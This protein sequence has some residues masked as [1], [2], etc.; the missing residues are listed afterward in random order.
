MTD[1]RQTVKESISI[2]ERIID[3]VRTTFA[4]MAFLDVSMTEPE[5]EETG[6]VGPWFSIN[7]LGNINGSLVL[8]LP[9]ELKKQITE[10]MFSCSWDDIPSNFKDDCLLEF[11]NVIGGRCV[12]GTSQKDGFLK[13]TIPTVVFDEDDLPDFPPALDLVMDAQEI[14]FR[15]LLYVSE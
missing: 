2:R 4:D 3:A 8:V 15:V 10:S 1:I 13:L 12:H 14:M 6:I 11:L 7:V 9:L 5:S